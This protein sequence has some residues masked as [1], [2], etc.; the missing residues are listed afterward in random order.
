MKNLLTSVLG[1]QSPNT[2]LADIVA[3]AEDC[4][5]RDVA[6]GQ[7]QIIDTQSNNAPIQS[8]TTPGQPRSAY[9]QNNFPNPVCTYTSNAGGRAVWTMINAPVDTSGRYMIQ[10]SGKTSP[11]Q[12][13]VSLLAQY[14]VE[15][16][17]GAVTVQRGVRFNSSPPN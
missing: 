4:Q 10:F 9:L 13:A 8:S 2:S 6:G 5:G 15:S 7:F 14:P 1:S 12:G 11:G 16:Y 17:A 3:G